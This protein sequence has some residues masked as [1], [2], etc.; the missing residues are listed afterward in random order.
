MIVDADTHIVLDVNPAACEMFGRLKENIVGRVCHKFIC[1]AE[2]GKCPITDLEKKVEA[3]EKSII[4]QDG[5]SISVLKS[6]ECVKVGDRK[7]LVE[8]FVDISERKKMEKDLQKSREKLK[9]IAITDELTGLYNRRG[10]M[11][12]AEKQLQIANRTKK[13]LYLL[14]ADLDNMKGINDELGHQIGDKALQDAAEVLKRISRESDIVSRIGGDEFAV[15]LTG[16]DNKNAIAERFEKEI[17][18]V[19]NSSE[20]PYTLS[21]STGVVSCNP[22]EEVCDLSKFMSRADSLMYEAKKAKK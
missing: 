19:N 7:L 20:R 2:V 22:S 4:R 18:R 11:T 8:S 17:Q 12:L 15:L 3:K 9:E 13:T 1:P 5:A 16:S 21:I 14:Y 10:F 6:V